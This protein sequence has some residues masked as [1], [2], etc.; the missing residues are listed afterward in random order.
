MFTNCHDGRWFTQVKGGILRERLR[1][2]SWVFNT[3]TTDHD[4]GLKI[5]GTW[6]NAASYRLC[7]PSSANMGILHAGSTA[8]LVIAV[9][10]HCLHLAICDG[11]LGCQEPDKSQNQNSHGQ[12]AIEIHVHHV[13][14]CLQ[15]NSA[16]LIL[17]KRVDDGLENC[18]LKRGS[19]SRRTKFV[20]CANPVVW[21]CLYI[22]DQRPKIRS[23]GRFL[24]DGMSMSCSPCGK[25]RCEPGG[26]ILFGG[27]KW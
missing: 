17:R 22:L 12:G 14:H 26:E 21:L 11:E 5:L 23:E 6:T 19:W 3:E 8:T 10:D 16:I 27:P 2:R 20:W 4:L 7:T 15:F 1:S 24:L 9:T 25:V 18:R 13:C